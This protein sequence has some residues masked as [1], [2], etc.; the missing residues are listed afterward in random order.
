MPQTGSS[1][2]YDVVLI[3]GGIMS[4]TLGTML[5]ELEPDWSIALYESLHQAGQESSD[6]WNNAGTGHAALCELN[7]SPAGPD[8]SVDI[9][10]A[11]NINE[12]FQVSLQY[13][14]H[15]IKNGSLVDPGN[16]INTIPHMSF[17]MGDEHADYLRTRYEAMSG[18]PLFSNMKHSE[19][20]DEISQWAPLLVE[21]RD[22]DQR[23]AASRVE[24][25]TDVNFGALSQQLINNLANDDVDVKYGHKVKGLS[26]DTDGRW[27]IAVK[28]T[29][30][31]E[32]F[33][34]KA[35]FVFIGAGGGALDLLQSTG[36]PESKGFG[37]FPIS[38]QFLRSTNQDVADEHNAKVYG[39]AATGAPPMSVPHL[40]TRFVNGRRSL[41]YG[42]YAGF[43]TNFLKSGS[44]LDLPK[45]VRP[46]NVWPMLNVAKDNFD[47]VGYLLSELTKTHGKKVDALRDFYPNAEDDQWELITAGQ[48]VQVMKKDKKKGGVLQFG[49][50]L[51]SGAEGSIA[52]LLGASPG[53][54]T[55]API[56][57]ELLRRS[58]PD[59]FNSWEAKLTDMIPSLGQRLNE[60]PQLLEQVKQETRKTLQLD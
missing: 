45:S 55:A 5:K 4:A 30:G 44:Y 22:A 60:N 35:R 40:D 25:G 7:Y 49:T 38:G 37:G 51:V 47:L 17:V 8:G 2:E 9:S 13:W 10:K 54:S 52:A 59:R 39:Q 11:I 6:P 32:K 56:M 16:F 33:T 21:G 12:Q 31:D 20:H 18:N 15:L 3:G 27:E 23:I 41:M 48:R 42:P 36:I 57:V 14:S 19:S 46:H 28:D 50:E 43:S 53:A 58:F 24:T 29:I 1:L 34:A 26:R